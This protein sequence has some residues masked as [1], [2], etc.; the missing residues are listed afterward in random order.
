MENVGKSTNL[1][2]IKNSKKNILFVD[3]DI[4]V[5]NNA[6]VDSLNSVCYD[7][8]IFDDATQYRQG[9][10]VND[11]FV[12]LK[13]LNLSRP[14]IILTSDFTFYRSSEEQIVYYPYHCFV[15]LDVCRTIEVDIKN[16]RNNYLGFLPWHLYFVRLLFLLKFVQQDWFNKCLVNYLPENILTD[17]QKK[18][19]YSSVQQLSP[20]ELFNL[21]QFHIDFPN[22]LV[23][24][25]NDDRLELQYINNCANTDCYINFMIESEYDLPFITEKTIKPYLCGQFSA[26][27]GN[28]LLYN[29]LEEIGIDIFKDYLDMYV[30]NV[31]IRERVDLTIEKLSKF[32][33]NIEQ[34]WIE[35][36]PR[37]LENYNYVRSTSFVDKLEFKI[38]QWVN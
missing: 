9:F 22:G 15:N 3:R 6:I 31:D 20:Q 32:M 26:V 1:H 34:S 17:F 12:K 16:L 14:W 2:F 23:A 27:L 11:F 18:I 36:Y 24:D 35:T 7:M 30:P 5:D 33:F 28:N 13:T 29:H 21:N 4:D 8:I 38:K 19:L 37:R 10:L 25:I